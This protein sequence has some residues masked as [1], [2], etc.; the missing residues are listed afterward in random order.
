MGGAA[1]P[2]PIDMGLSDAQ[3]ATFVREGAVV[4]P[5]LVSEELRAAALAALG[6]EDRAGDDPAVLALYHRSPLAALFDGLLGGGTQPV[7]GS[8]IAFRQPTPEE[9]LGRYMELD[10]ESCPPLARWNGHMDGV[11]IHPGEHPD[12]PD[13]QAPIQSFSCLAGVAL[14]DQLEP[15]CGNFAVQIGSHRSNAAFFAE[16]NE[17]GGPLGPGGPGWPVEPWR[18]EDGSNASRGSP[19]HLR[20][21]MVPPPTRSFGEG[22]AEWDGPD[23]GPPTSRWWPHGTQQLLRAGDVVLA[24][25]LTCHGEMLRHVGD[26]SRDMIFFRVKHREHTTYRPAEHGQTPEAIRAAQM[27]SDPWFEWVFDGPQD[28]EGQ[29]RL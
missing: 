16:Q 22:A 19:P 5:G 18:R 6:G 7:T 26:R 2:Q 24:H 28:A 9:D 25:F 13:L 15:D 4:L 14:N 27:L 20:A 8:Q 10:V 1:L 21:R 12:D 17:A 11:A 3:R 29:A 23:G